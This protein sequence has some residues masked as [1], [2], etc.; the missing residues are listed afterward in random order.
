MEG[1]IMTS[2]HMMLTI[3]V[4]IIIVSVFTVQLDLNLIHACREL[5]CMH[6][7][8]ACN[9]NMASNLI[10]LTLLASFSCQQHTWTHQ[11]MYY[12]NMHFMNMHFINTCFGIQ[13]HSFSMCNK[14]EQVLGF[15]LASI[16]VRMIQIMLQFARYVNVYCY[17]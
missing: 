16:N 14:H 9:L 3:I 13:T 10:L 15:S 6:T 11:N 2:N 5:A 4:L 8:L 12:M 1:F 7:F 17:T